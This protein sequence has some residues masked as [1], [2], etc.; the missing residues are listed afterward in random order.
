MMKYLLVLLMFLQLLN[1]PFSQNADSTYITPLGSELKGIYIGGGIFFVGGAALGG[2][3]NNFSSSGGNALLPF[4]TGLW[5]S[6]PGS[7]IGFGIGAAMAKT[8]SR[9]DGAFQFSSGLAFAP[10]FF[11][12]LKKNTLVGL[13]FRII[14]P[15]ISNWRYSLSMN[16]YF[17]DSFMEFTFDWTEINVDLQYIMTITES[18]LFYPFI[19]TNWRIK[20]TTGS[21]DSSTLDDGGINYGIGLNVKVLGRLKIFGETRYSYTQSEEGW[22]I[23]SLGAQFSL[24]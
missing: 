23:S 9:K 17:S 1:T 5:A 21:F 16:K 3:A 22:L 14:S 19:G 10:N 11:R 6:V 24:K 7:I 20:K 12:P 4:H 8:H 18:V 15:G 2:I 13:H